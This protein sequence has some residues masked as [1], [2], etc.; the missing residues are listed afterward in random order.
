M[1]SNE[2]YEAMENGKKITHKYFTS[3]QYLCMHDDGYIYDENG[4]CWSIESVFPQTAWE[5]Y[6]EHNKNEWKIWEENQCQKN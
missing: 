2:A 5:E 4:Y 3:K 6:I 1:N